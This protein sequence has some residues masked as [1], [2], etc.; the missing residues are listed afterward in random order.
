MAKIVTQIGWFGQDDIE[1][2]QDLERLRLMLE[3]MPDS[4]LIKHLNRERGN[5]RN[6]NPVDAMW[7]SILAGVLYQHSSIEELRRDLARNKDLRRI[8]G[9]DD[10]QPVPSKDAYSRFLKLLIMKREYIH[11][12]FNLLVEAL[13]EAI[14]DFGK[15]IAMDSK[16]IASHANKENVNRKKDGRRDLDADR[17]YKTYKGIDKDGNAWEKVK[18]WYGYKIHLIVDAKYELPVDFMVTKASK[19]DILT[20]HKLV[21]DLSKKHPDILNKKMAGA[22][23]CPLTRDMTTVS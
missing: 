18:S 10:G 23:K 5:G 9:F 6:D 4:V 11:N 13:K 8:C 12:I 14:P 1:S 20:G 3:Y 19:P 21:D 2:L 7:N 17:G 22:M 15:T 16:A